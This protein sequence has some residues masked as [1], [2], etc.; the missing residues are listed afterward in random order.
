M[1]ETIASNLK[2]YREGQHFSQESLAQKV[3]ISCQ[4]LNEYENAITLANSKILSALARALGITL[5]DLLLAKS[6]NKTSFRFRSHASFAKDKQPQLL[7][8]VLR[9]L[10]TYNLLEKAVG[11]PPYAPE[12]TSCHQIEGNEKHIQTTATRFRRSLGLGEGKIYNLFEAVEAVGLKVLCTPIPIKNFFG[13]SA[14]SSAEG[15]FVLVNTHNITIERQ[16]FTLAHEIGHLIFHRD[17]YQDT[18]LEEGTK[19]EEKMR[20]TVA[21]YFAGNLLVPD[22]ELERLYDQ[23]YDIIPLKEYFRV[24]YQV[25]LKRLDQMQFIDYSQK[26]KKIKA[27]YKRKNN[28][29]PLNNSTELPPTLKEEEFPENQRYKKLIWQSLDLGKISELKAAELLQ[30]TVEELGLRRQEAEVYAIR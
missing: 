29:V 11:I 8:Q 16:I 22:L 4:N 13:L 30:I 1:K 2:H 19:E 5:D 6:Q 7:T 9:M 25:I 14:C 15:A 20:E 18:L 24:S 21:N 12:T 10:E 17:D 23:N 28:G 3:G 26:I 27:I